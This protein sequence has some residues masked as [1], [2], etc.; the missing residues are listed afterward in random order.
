MYVSS[1]QLN[2]KLKYELLNLD[3]TSP[4]SLI[5]IVVVANAMVGPRSWIGGIFSRSGNRR[6]GSEKFTDYP[7][8][9]L[10]VNEDANNT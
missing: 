4:N 10:Q 9:H 8:S 7:L 3:P 5:I 2:G 6:Y 1:V